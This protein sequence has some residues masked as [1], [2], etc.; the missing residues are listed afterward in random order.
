MSEIDDLVTTRALVVR[1]DGTAEVVRVSRRLESWQELVGGSIE[2]LSLSAEVRAFINEDGKALGLAMNVY[3]DA[4][5]RAL[6]KSVGHT[7]MPGDYIVGPVVFLGPVDRYGYETDVHPLVVEMA[8]LALDL[9]EIPG[10][11]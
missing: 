9:S 10:E 1:P 5:I 11:P 7:L 6:L 2:G 3:A 8:K 4:M